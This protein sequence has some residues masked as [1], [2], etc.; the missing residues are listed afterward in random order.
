MMM[1]L[2][3]VHPSS[4]PSP[5]GRRGG[6]YALWEKSAVTPHPNLL[7]E[8]EGANPSPSGR[9]CN[10]F[11]LPL[12]EACDPLWKKPAIYSLSLWKKPAIHPLSLWERARVRVKAQ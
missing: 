12:G 3:S 10:L 8:G 2:L 4:Q 7:P 11:P 1:C 9:A 6:C 5:R